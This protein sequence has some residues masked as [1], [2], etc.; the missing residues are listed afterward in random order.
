MGRKIE[1]DLKDILRIYKLLEEINDF[2][3]QPMNFKDVDKF[4][5]ENYKE[6]SAIYYDV[7]WNWLPEDIKED[8]TD[9]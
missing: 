6:I 5:Q 7:I 2:F 1:I 9:E 4:A 3:H 8:I